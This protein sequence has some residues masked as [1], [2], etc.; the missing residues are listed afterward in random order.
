[1]KTTNE[2]L[3][4][5]RGAMKAAGANACLIP[6]SDPHASEYLP[7]HWAARS[8]FSGFTG[9]VGTLV[10]TETASALWADGRYFIQAE[11]QLAGSEIELQRIGVEGVPTVEEY[12]SA[13]LG[14]GQVLALD[15]MVTPTATVRSLQ[16]ALAA[17]GARIESVDLVEGNWEGRPPVPATP[18]FLLGTE[19]AGLSARE[20]LAQVRAALA[21]KKAGAMVVTRLDSVAWLLNLRAAD[22]DCTPFALAFCFVT[23]DDA[24]LFINSERLPAEAAAALGDEGVRVMDYEKLLGAL[25]GYH[26]DQ[27]VLV[28]TAGANWAVYTALESNPC[29]TLVEGEDPIQALKAVKNPTEIENLKNAH[30]KDG[31]AMVRFAIWLEGEM[32][33]GRPVAE[34]DVEQKLLE[35]RGEQPH[36]LGA[37]FDTIAAY[38]ANAAMMHYHATP[39]NCSTLEPR[40]FLLVDCGGQ[41]LDGTTD[42]TRTYPLGPLTENERTYYT[43]VLKSHIDLAKLQFLAGCTGGNLDVIARAPV[44]AHG[45][46][47]RCGTGHG[48]GFLGGVHEG[49]HNL[50]ITNNVVFQPGMVVTDEP[51]IYEEGE[52]GIR[53]ENELVCVERE[54][55]Q[56]GRFLGF[57]PV[58]YC[59]IDLTPVRAELLDASEKEWLNAFHKTVYD[60]LAPRLTEPERAWLAGRTRPLA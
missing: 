29:F 43:Y 44:W 2:K 24:M 7:D 18:A 41:Y 6:S 47:Y 1:M 42:I 35:L 58:T 32:A 19:Y 54:K 12:L 56:Y 4:L 60:T 40:G 53:I 26:H 5:L 22:I 36:N 48:V 49:P 55:N 38:G 45:I 51:G 27:A 11:R 20:K 9:S 59:P 46:D 50:R 3:A 34:V 16:K 25:T 15:G 37:S 33:A 10:V 57:E 52:V 39:E 14:E 30:A 8:Y 28:D 13:A 23:P 21:E 31:V 17:K